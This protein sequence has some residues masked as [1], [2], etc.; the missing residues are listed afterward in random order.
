MSE[1]PKGWVATQ[2]ALIAKVESGVGFPKKYQGLD[3]V[4][5][6]VYKVGD[7]SRSVQNQE[8]SLV[9]SS[10]YV[11]EKTR[12]AMNAKIYPEGSTLFAKIGEALKLNRRGFV[13]KEGI[14]DNNVMGVIPDTQLISAKFIFYFLKTVDLS[15]FSRSSTVP[16]IRKGDVENLVLCLAPLAEQK[17]IVA[18]L[19][20]VLAQVDTIKAR[21]DRIPAI[22]KRFRQSVLAA[23]VSGKLTEE[24]RGNVALVDSVTERYE[25]FRDKILADAN[26]AAQKSKLVKIH[27][28]SESTEFPITIPDC[29]NLKNLSKVAFGF[30]YGS[31]AKSQAIGDVPVLRMGNI[32][33]GKLDWGDLVYTSDL[34]EIEKYRLVK[35]DVLFNRTNSPELV[36]KT[37]IF[38]GEREA[39]YAGYLIKVQ[40]SELLSPEFLN[41]ALNSAHA[42]NYCMRVKTDGVS[43][44]NINAQK[45]GYFPCPL[46]LIEEQ[47]EIVRLVDQY[48]VFADSIEAQVKKAQARVDNLTQ[49]I[50][51]KAFSGELVAQDPNDEPADKLLERIAKAR[52]EAEQ[53]AKAA[54]KAVKSQR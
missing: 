45:L 22:L 36:G 3:F 7:I 42:K 27:E 54:K 18:K 13:G 23:A 26:S 20:E 14:A 31:S 19:D 35:G 15:E 53:L 12:I 17:R 46:P 30:N 39:I 38:H 48:F 50:L 40:G 2:I 32:Q 28:Q 52:T 51:A 34:S 16:S 47:T 37:T 21:L 9:R 41:I 44:S 8:K 4:D 24:W 5:I 1:L 43:Q 49:S 25:K 10:N 33:N 6:P 29:W 11:D